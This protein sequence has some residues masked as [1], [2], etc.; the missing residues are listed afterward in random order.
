[1]LNY[2]TLREIQKKELE[3]AAL[4]QLEGDFYEKV[5]ELLRKRSQE[6]MNSKSFLAIKEYENIRKIVISIQIKREEK[7]ALM[8][9]RGEGEPKGI[10]SEEKEFLEKFVGI[11]NSMRESIKDRWETKESGISAKKD[12]RVKVLKD[13][14]QYKGIDNNIYGP[15]KVGEEINLPEEEANWLLK[16]KIAESI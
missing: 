3:S 7:L 12:R 14:E 15:F 9:L 1:M 10:T 5:N 13:V 11:I 4:T 2:A 8:G 6:A 16:T